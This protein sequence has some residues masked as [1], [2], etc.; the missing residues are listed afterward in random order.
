MRK[1]ANELEKTSITCAA[2]LC[3]GLVTIWKVL[4]AVES[5]SVSVTGRVSVL[6]AAVVELLLHFKLLHH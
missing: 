5:E 6:H 3:H 2:G 1:E 4:P